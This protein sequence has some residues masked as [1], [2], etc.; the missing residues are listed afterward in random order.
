MTVEP[1][2]SPAA[3]DPTDHPH[4]RHDPL[5]DQWVLVSPHR[6]RRPWQGQV[7][8]LPLERKPAYDP[9]CY[10]CP[11]NA[12]AGDARNPAYDDVFVFTNDFAALLPETPE[13][14]T[15]I[16][17][18]FRSATA[19][20]T[21]RVLCF[22]PRHDLTLAELPVRQLRR[23]VD[24]WAEQTVE[25]G[26]TY[27]WVQVFENKG[28][29]MGA[30]NPHPH[31]QVWA[32]DA[33]PTLAA[34]EDA[35]QRAY[36]AGHGSVLLLD[37]ARAEAER[38][39]RVV[40]RDEHWLVVVPYWAVWPFELL[41]LPARRHVARLPDLRDDEREALAGLLRRAFTRLDNLFETS[42]AYSFGWHGAPYGTAGDT[43]A[44]SA[45]QLHA[46]V[47]PPLLRSASVRKFMVGF[48]LLAEPQRDLTPEQAAERLR[49][50]PDE[51]Y[52][53]RA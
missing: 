47:Y 32:V 52:R 7:E 36:R 31:G 10:L 44:V 35:C 24:L 27:S 18:L 53:E 49:P 51:H 2:P 23:V 8:S 33:L 11:G 17:P 40:L 4:R 34:R 50:L 48:E 41:I 16:D 12:R 19:R 5:Q 6:T 3:F 43:G 22:S 21:S 45:W 28:N 46:H 13:A 25:L 20:G 38:G 1:P 39:E 14:P 37:Y 15:G 26:G 29:I 30:S 42:F 9:Q